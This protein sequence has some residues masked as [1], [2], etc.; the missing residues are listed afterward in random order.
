[1]GWTTVNNLLDTDFSVTDNWL[2]DRYIIA[3]LRIDK[4]VLPANLFRAHLEK[5][6]E[7]WCKAKDQKRCPAQVKAELKDLLTAEMLSKTLP[8]VKA[9]EFCWNI[10]DGWVFLHNN[11]DSVNERFLKLFFET[12]GLELQPASPLDFLVE[13][14]QTLRKLE[15]AGVSDLSMPDGGQS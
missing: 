3:Q 4:K 2:Y 14:P 6:M 7:D 5:R 9:I 10:V 1:M 12:F 8:R 15:I 11:S 13:T